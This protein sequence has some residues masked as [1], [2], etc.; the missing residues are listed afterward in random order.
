MSADY[1]RVRALFE[2]LIDCDAATREQRL[3]ALDDP[4]LAAEVRALLQDPAADDDVAVAERIARAAA[5]ALDDDPTPPGTMLGAYRVERELGR[6]GMGR[7]LLAARDDGAFRQRV[8]VKLIAGLASASDRARLLRERQVLADL[9]HPGI[10]RLIDG[11]ATAQG[12]PYL[13]M[14]YVEGRLLPEW[15]DA[16]RPDL[17][18]RLRLVERLA[19]ATHYAHQHQVIHCDI[20]PA[21]V[22]VRA[23]GAPVLLDFGIARLVDPEQGAARTGTLL[24]TP[25]YASPEQLDGRRLT[26]ATDVFALGLVLYELLTGELP[27][28]E[29]DARQF[30]GELPA[31]SQI[32]RRHD[33][34]LARRLRGDLDRIVARAIRIDPAARYA[35]AAEL[36]SDLAAWR[37]GRPVQAT[38]DDL[39]YLLRVFV[40]RHRVPVAIAAS[41]FL[42]LCVV[43]VLLAVEMRRA[44]AAEQQT[45]IEAASARAVAS[46][47]EDLF[48]ELDPELNGAREL[49]ALALLDRGAERLQAMDAATPELKARLAASLG[50]IYANAARP[51]EALRLID[52]ALAGEGIDAGTRSALLGRRAAALNLLDDHAGAVTEATRA[53]RLARERGDVAAAAHAASEVAVA[54]AGLSRH[55]EAEAALARAESGF[56]TLAGGDDPSQ[57]ERGRRGLASVLHNRGYLRHRRGDAAGAIPAL[58]RAIAVKRTVFGADHPKTL[59]SIYLRGVVQLG[60]GQADAVEAD[61]RV[62]LDGYRKAHGEAS[63]RYRETLAELAVLELDRG[64]YAEAERAFQ[65]LLGADAL[66]PTRTPDSQQAILLNNLGSLYEERGDV[67]RAAAHYAAS[68]AQRR[69]LFGDAAIATARA[70]HNLARVWVEAGRVDLALPPHRLALAAREADAGVKAEERWSSRLLDAWIVLAGQD[71]GAQAAARATLAAAEAFLDG[72]DAPQSPRATIGLLRLLESAHAADANAKA[73]RRAAQ[74]LADASAAFYPESH[75][76]RERDRA[77]LV[78]A[79]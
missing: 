46:F 58:G 36:A 14:E 28:R 35:S 78:G 77:R 70:A 47:L 26:S 51:R 73:R 23:D 76:M 11:G 66:S 45:R 55:A 4:A 34:P 74:R 33:R 13:V 3:A 52:E 2:A 71:Q 69:V 75:P 62:A 63:L 43:G 30:T 40:R 65:S 5:R 22:I 1:A 59:N 19:E 44:R 57:V 29:L 12:E 31:P 6:G 68:L 27:P 72:A 41:L 25:R 8:A 16:T 39:G 79:R 56:E 49:G 61:Y 64:R 38:G 67:D 53:E 48:E 17:A 60:L 20:K 10:T 7:V 24:A 50:T 37:E 32:A 21:N 18:A 15:L 54:Y 9:D 42:G